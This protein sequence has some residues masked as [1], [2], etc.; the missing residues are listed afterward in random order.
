M[1][2]NVTVMSEL[3]KIKPLR[4]LLTEQLRGG[5]SSALKLWIFR[6]VIFIF[7]RIYSV[8]AC[9]CTRVSRLVCSTVANR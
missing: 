1:C 3:V 7:E 6:V 4:S 9:V 2:N 8:Y 5:Q